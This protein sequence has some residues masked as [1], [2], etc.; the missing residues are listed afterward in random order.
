VHGWVTAKKASDRDRILPRYTVAYDFWPDHEFDKPYQRARPI[1]DM[2]QFREGMEANLREFLARWPHPDPEGRQSFKEMFQR[3]R[4]E[5]KREKE[6]YDGFGRKAP[7]CPR[8]DPYCIGG[9][10]SGSTDVSPG[11]Y[12]SLTA[13]EPVPVTLV[14]GKHWLHTIGR[15][16][17][18][19]VWRVPLW[20][21]EDLLFGLFLLG[22]AI[23]CGVG[24]I[25]ERRRLR[26]ATRI[27]KE[28]SSDEKAP[29]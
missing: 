5:S 8:E 22:T 1:A 11:E 23:L 12:D 16:N 6:F 17:S 28:S 9:R 20:R 19:R 7:R 15:V 13:R 3:W 25:A 2:G 4:E 10:C 18:R 26:R 21:I 29:R 24:A 14:A 27:Q